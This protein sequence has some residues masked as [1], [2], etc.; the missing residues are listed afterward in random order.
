MPRFE[1]AIYKIYGTGK[2]I[3]IAEYSGWEA[4]YKKNGPD[5][6]KPYASDRKFTAITL[7]LADLLVLSSNDFQSMRIEFPSLFKELLNLASQEMRTSLNQK[8]EK[9]KEEEKND[10]SEKYLSMMSIKVVNNL[11]NNLN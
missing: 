4:F 9:I 2:I 3:G 7:K 1:N 8:L 10:A 6:I 5:D 11:K